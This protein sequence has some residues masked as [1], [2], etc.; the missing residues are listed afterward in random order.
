MFAAWSLAMVACAIFLDACVGYGQTAL[1]LI[2]HRTYVS[3][4]VASFGPKRTS[5]SQMT[6]SEYVSRPSSSFIPGSQSCSA[7]ALTTW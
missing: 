3:A 1:T 6:G 5:A 2:S 4:P 7:E